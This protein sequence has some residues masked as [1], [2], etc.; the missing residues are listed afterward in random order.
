MSNTSY[1][2]L[3]IPLAVANADLTIQARRYGHGP[4][5]VV[6]SNMD[7]NDANEWSSFVEA[8]SQYDGFSV[9]TYA[10]PEDLSL[11]EDALSAVLDFVELG[12]GEDVKQKIVLL[13]ASLGGV[14]SL[15]AAAKRGDERI[16][17]VIAISTP[18]ERNGTTLV[19]EAELRMLNF[20]K[21]LIA[22]EFD[23]CVESTRDIFA[24][25]EDPRQLTVYPGEGH[26]TGIFGEHEESLV[27]Q[28]TE[29][30]RWVLQ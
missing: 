16:F 26:G 18:M 21:L 13:G 20:H 14:A 9:V 23:E 30:I 5:I 6:I 10:Y 24:L 27:Q 19:T 1:E 3:D 12:V 25:S 11:A 8:M 15:K 17:A 22:S 29:Y 28:L 7:T 2:T 4:G